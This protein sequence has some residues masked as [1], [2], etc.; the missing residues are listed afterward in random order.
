MTRARANGI[1]LDFDSFGSPKGRPLL[2]IMGLGGQSIMWDEGFC[3][4]LAERGQF[5]VRYD[6]R[7]V[8]LSTKFDAAGIPNLTEL[9]MQSAAGKTPAVPYTLDDM[10]DDAAGLL[11]ALGL[12]TAHVC[13]ASM[14]GMIAQ[15][16][17]IRH[18]R[19]LRSLTSIMSS[20]GN[21]SLPQARPTASP[22]AAAKRAAFV[23]SAAPRPSRCAR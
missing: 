13:G 10:A 18:G 21:P 14:G 20:T 7:D 6:N 5:V 23:T 2:L 4:A 3:E 9:M 11:D 22:S 17:A 1:E 8:G 16:V 12:D 19:R 15:T